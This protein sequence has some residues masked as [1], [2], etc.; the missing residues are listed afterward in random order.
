MRGWVLIA[1]NRDRGRAMVAAGGFVGV[2]VDAGGSLAQKREINSYVYGGL[3]ANASSYEVWA[4]TR[5][6]AQGAEEKGLFGRGPIASW[7]VERGRV[8]RFWMLG[9]TGEVVACGGDVVGEV[10]SQID[11]I[12]DVD[13]GEGIGWFL[14]TVSAAMKHE[15]DN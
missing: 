3:C 11:V 7:W 8:R 15:V 13:E 6:Y 10:L 2:V 14:S 12:F 9:C 4:E 1:A 5:V